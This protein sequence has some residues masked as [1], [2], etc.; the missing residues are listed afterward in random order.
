MNI[1]AAGSMPSSAVAALLAARPAVAHQGVQAAA[2]VVRASD[3]QAA[4]EA[5]ISSG[6]QTGSVDTYL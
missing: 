6:S 2:M 4:S 3:A 1:S 5:A